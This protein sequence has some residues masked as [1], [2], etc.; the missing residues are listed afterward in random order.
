[1]DRRPGLA[2]HNIVSADLELVTVR[3]DPA[4]WATLP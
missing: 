3:G 4:R 1:V 2:G